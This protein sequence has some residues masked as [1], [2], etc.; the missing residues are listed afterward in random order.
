MGGEIRDMMDSCH[1]RRTDSTLVPSNRTMGAGF[2][3]AQRN[4]PG[5]SSFT[6]ITAKPCMSTALRGNSRSA[7]FPKGC[8]SYIVATT[9]RASIL[10]IFGLAPRLTTTATGPARVG[11][12]CAMYALKVMHTLMRTPVT[13]LT[14]LA[15]VSPAT[16][17][18]SEGT[19]LGYGV[20][21]H[22]R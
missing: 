4:P 22:R 20:D 12:S 15:V 3:S 11:R 9:R 21:P 2:S 18:N 8:A 1:Q 16:V 14:A 7:R 5:T 6:A 13:S 19:W 10:N 17:S